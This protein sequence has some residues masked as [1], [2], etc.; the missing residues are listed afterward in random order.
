MRM[1]SAEQVVTGEQK[2]MMVILPKS[3]QNNERAKL[4]ELR[5]RELHCRFRAKDAC[6]KTLNVG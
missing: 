1:L 2:V 5:V 4:A 6:V 3:I